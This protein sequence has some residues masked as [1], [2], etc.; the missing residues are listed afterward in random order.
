VDYEEAASILNKSPRGAA[1]LLR[2]ALQKLM[3]ELGESGKDINKDIASLVQ[4]GLPVEI[5]QA[6]DIVRVIGN[7]SVHPGQLDMKDDHETAV[8]LFELI[9]FIVEDRIA[10][11]KKIQALYNRLPETKRQAIEK[12]DKVKS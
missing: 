8:Q 7:E 4:K 2:L 11:P 10:R 3:K 12:R 9:N 6:L 1:A 5:Q